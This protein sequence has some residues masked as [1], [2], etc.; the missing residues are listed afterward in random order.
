[1]L[2]K[3]SVVRNAAADAD[4]EDVFDVLESALKIKKR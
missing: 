4:E 3:V 2:A 1:M